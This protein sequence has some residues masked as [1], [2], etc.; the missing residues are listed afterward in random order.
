MNG[1]GERENGKLFNFRP[2]LFAAIFLVFGVTFAYYRIERGVSYL[3]ALLL[4]PAVGLPLF[5]ADGWENFLVRFCAV[6]LLAGVFCVGFISFRS[7]VNAFED[8]PYYA[9]RVELVG[10]VETRKEQ[11]ELVA[12]TLNAVYIDGEKVKG[13]AVAYFPDYLV[14]EIGVGEKVLLVGE[15]KTERNT[16]GKYGFR[17]SEITK[18][19]C[20]RLIGE[21]CVY[22]GKSRDPFLIV[23]ARM[24]EVVYAGMDETPAA[25]TLALLTG[26]VTGVDEGLMDNMRYGGIAH[27]FAVSGLNIGALY[28]C[29]SFL[30]SRAPFKRTPKPVRFLLLAGILFFYSGVCGFSAS[31]VRAAITCAVFY[32]ARLLGTGSDPLNALG[33]AAIFILLLSPVELLGVGFQLSFLA[34]LGLFLLVKPTTQVF[35]ELRKV[36]YK[37]FPRRYTAEE[38]EVLNN[39]DVLPPTVGDSVWKWSTGILSASI[40]AQVA[41]LPALLFHFG[42]ISGWALLLNFLFV[43]ITDL[44]FTVALLLVSL[45]CLLPTAASGV[46]LYFP[47]LA[48]SGSILLFQIVDF[49][50]FGLS[51][52]Q[53]SLGIC[54]CY[55][56]GILFLTDKLQISPRL[57]RTLAVVCFAA[58]ALTLHLYNL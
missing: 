33:V 27:I 23:R 45:C 50:R 58:F 28:L 29:C 49:S 43:P 11:E 4:L 12:L 48:W 35:D 6:T 2:A 13:R 18:N 15:L 52:V 26:D 16:Q 51:G 32:F 44:L 22:A 1:I 20:Y 47:S 3:W 17:E 10:T 24:E 36:Y 57:R 9:G 53:V 8:N 7:Q 42:Y 54:V 55:Y 39:G 37:R 46:L 41:T 5:F 14:E 56:G 19:L 40:A 25:L 30:F 38:Q 31:V 21:S 34:C